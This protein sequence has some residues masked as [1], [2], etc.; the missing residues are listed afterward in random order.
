MTKNYGWKR[1]LPDFR[2][3]ELTLTTSVLPAKVDLTSQ[4]PP[5][6]DQGQLGSCTANAIAAALDFDR[7]KQGETFVNPSRL[8]IYY[9]ERA[10]EGTVKSDSGAAIRDGIKVVNTQGACKEVTWPYTISKFKSKPVIAAYKEGL[11]YESVKYQ[12][13]DNTNLT[14]LKTALASGLPFVFGFSVYSSFE[15][16][17][18]A[19][20][21]IVPMPAKNESLLGGHAVLCVG[22]DDSTQRFLVRNSW[23]PG[24]G[25]KGYFTIPYTYLTNKNLASD[26]W[27]IQSVK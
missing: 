14:S 22:Y 8:F 26:F 9:N 5:V 17:A 23:G 21:G 20:T 16:T 2:D 10:M 15:S 3:L 13:L 25:I 6:Y 4:C 12:G 7:H 11:L 19:S 24:W 1:Q 18:V 27:V